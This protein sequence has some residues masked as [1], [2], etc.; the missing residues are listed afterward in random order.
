MRNAITVVALLI[1]MTGIFVSLAREELRCKLGLNST[2]CPP[3]SSRTNFRQENQPHFSLPRILKNHSTTTETGKNEEKSTAI[4][5]ASPESPKASDI[6]TTKTE[7]MG[8]KLLNSD[9]EPANTTKNETAPLNSGPSHPE[10]VENAKAT[11]EY[12]SQESSQM[13]QENQN[14][15]SHDSSP[16]QPASHLAPDGQPIPVI[17]PS[18]VASP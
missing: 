14:N 7:A 5:Q 8:N 2:D 18:P 4:P 12:P 16:A 3:I 6:D 1:S 15:P 17:P 10:P 11:S 13:D 9:S